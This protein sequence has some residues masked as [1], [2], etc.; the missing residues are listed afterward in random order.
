MYKYLVYVAERTE[1]L[2]LY[3]HIYRKHM[4]LFNDPLFKALFETT[5][6]RV[7]LKANIP[8]FTIIA[9]NSAYELATHN[10][11]RDI[12]GISL[13][14]AYAPEHADGDGATI[15][16][17][18]LMRASINQE[19]VYLAPFRYNIPSATPGEMQENWWELE[20]NYIAETVRRPALLLATTY[21]VTERV[22]NRESIDEGLKREQ[23]MDKALMTMNEDLSVANEELAA[24]NEELI[25][26]VDELHMVNGE[27]QMM[28][29][30]LMHAQLKLRSLYAELEKRVERRTRALAENEQQ[31]RQMADSIIQMVWVTDQAGNPEYFNQRWIDFAGDLAGSTEE[32]YWKCLFH[33]D[34]KER[35]REIWKHSLATGDPYE[36]EYRLRNCKGEYVWVLGRA[37]PF[38]NKE[39]KITKW[40]G[41]CTDI[42]ELKQRMSQ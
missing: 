29:E 42:N 7:V 9:Y 26:T 38:F 34:D 25:F 23:Q 17:E 18:G 41:T 1:T 32:V 10:T 22:L 33:P 35:V 6:P 11:G 30:E 40:F 8:D 28:N 36:M 5:L 12:T 31:F 2:Y 13:W 24:A 4:D 16:P 14:E 20:I 15:L 3:S 21:N 39:G 27:L 37:S 19:T